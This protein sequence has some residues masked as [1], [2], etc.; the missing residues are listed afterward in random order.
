MTI[1]MQ[2]DEPAVGLPRSAPCS[3]LLSGRWPFSP[4]SWSSLRACKTNAYV[5]TQAFKVFKE[6][7]EHLQ[8]VNC[9][10]SPVLSGHEHQEGAKGLWTS[11]LIDRISG[12]ITVNNIQGQNK[13]GVEVETEQKTPSRLQAGVDIVTQPLL[14]CF[15]LQSNARARTAAGL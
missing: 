7:T 4:G 8:R 15:R 10:L 3:S 14:S 11:H 12:A 2:M 9:I 13:A 5:E 1:K 6:T